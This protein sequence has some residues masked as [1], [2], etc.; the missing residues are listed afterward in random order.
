MIEQFLDDMKE[1]MAD[2][3]YVRL[4]IVS[5]DQLRDPI[6]I[7]WATVQNLDLEAILAHIEKV[8][9]SNENFYLHSGVLITI[10]HIHN[11]Q[12]AGYSKIEPL[13]NDNKPLTNLYFLFFC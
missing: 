9:Q 4:V 12:G 1:G 3:D 8:L 6:S 5:E 10:H 13:A 11:P 7:E 2:K